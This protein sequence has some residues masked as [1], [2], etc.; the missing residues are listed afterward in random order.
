MT[1][2]RMKLV[3]RLS[4]EYAARATHSG[5]G[6]PVVAFLAGATNEKIAQMYRAEGKAEAYEEAIYIVQKRETL[7]VTE[8]NLHH[9]VLLERERLAAL[10]GEG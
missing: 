6:K 4:E 10:L 5:L 8:L 9:R 3:E 2:R 1:E 7:G